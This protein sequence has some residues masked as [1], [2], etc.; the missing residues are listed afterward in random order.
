VLKET[1]K[2]IKQ[3]HQQLVKSQ[4]QEKLVLKELEMMKEVV[5]M[6]KKEGLKHH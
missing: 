2:K 6:E 5:E 4:I 1:N 3:L